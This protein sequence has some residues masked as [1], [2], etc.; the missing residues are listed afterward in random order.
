MK[1]LAVTL[2][3]VCCLATRVEAGKYNSVLNVGD[4]A[5]KWER[6]PGVDGKEHALADLADKKVVVV[7]F[8]CNSCPVAS[9][10]EDRILAFSKKYAGPSGSVG[11][12]A[13]NVNK[14]PED[15]L[16]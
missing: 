11:L 14:V 4:A 1:F 5:P 9:D 12:V 3:I 16:A 7:V 8:T 15:S 10:Y 2:G 6:L 13:I